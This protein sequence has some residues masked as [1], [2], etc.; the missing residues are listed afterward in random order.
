M[1]KKVGDKRAQVSVFVIIGIVIVAGLFIFLFFLKDYQNKNGMNTD[2]IKNFVSDCIKQTGGEVVF[3]V[4]KG[5]GYFSPANFSTDS[6]VAYYYSDGKGYIPEKT[7]IEKEISFYLERKLFLCTGNFADFPDFNISQDDIKI[8]T[9]IKDNSVEFDVVYPLSISK[10]GNTERLK[11]FKEEIPVRFGILY[12]SAK[13]I[14]DEQLSHESICLTCLLNVSVKNNFYADMIDYDN[15][16]VIF[17]FRDEKSK[18]DDK[19]FILAFANKY[20]L[21]EK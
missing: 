17:S 1:K 6:G 7:D 16:T 11:S 14:V 2:E 18:I 12:D 8:E 13:S 10:N 19:M 3:K 5:G 9:K 15:E 4:G 20:K 21:G